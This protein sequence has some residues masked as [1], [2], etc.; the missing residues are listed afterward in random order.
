MK[1]PKIRS[2]ETSNIKTARGTDLRKL[3]SYLCHEKSIFRVDLSISTWLTTPI[4]SAD[5]LTNS[6]LSICLH[7]LPCTEVRPVLR[8]PWHLWRHAVGAFI[9]RS[10]TVS[11]CGLRQTRS[12]GELP[13]GDGFRASASGRGR[14]YWR[15]R[16]VR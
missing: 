9:L 3:K 2:A 13:R 15:Q 14:S 8:R 12:C 10:Y 6:S 11:R 4:S 7:G 1:N 16:S 5:A